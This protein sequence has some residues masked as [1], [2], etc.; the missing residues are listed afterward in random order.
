MEVLVG[1]A[2]STGKPTPFGFLFLFFLRLYG[3]VYLQRKSHNKRRRILGL[4]S[5]G[6]RCR[7]AR[8][9]TDNF[10]VLVDAKHWMPPWFSNNK[11]LFDL[12]SLS[13]ISACCCCCMDQI[14]C[15]LGLGEC[16]HCPYIFIFSAIALLN[17]PAESE[18]SCSYIFVW[19]AWFKMSQARKEVVF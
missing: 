9:V 14:G 18:G 6:F 12:V 7:C 16:L 15:F 17:S 10:T 3:H 13:S 4:V 1:T 19:H 2:L 5:L 8:N 11:Q